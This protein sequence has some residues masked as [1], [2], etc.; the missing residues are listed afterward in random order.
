MPSSSKLQLF[1]EEAEA[2]SNDGEAV[3][4]IGGSALPLASANHE[5]CLILDLLHGTRRD[6]GVMCLS[7]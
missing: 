3:P 6:D 1:K 4:D 5:R 2:E 7:E